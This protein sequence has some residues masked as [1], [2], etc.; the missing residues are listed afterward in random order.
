MKT[1]EI[2]MGWNYARYVDKVAEAGKGE[3][4]I[5]MFV[6]AWLPAP[7]DKGP[8]DYPSGGPQ[9][10]MHDIWR[11]AAPHVDMLCPDIYMTNF[12]E[13]AERYSRSGNILFVPECAGDIHGAAN[14]FYAIGQHKAVGYSSMGIG[15]LQ[16]LT[17]FRAGDAGSVAPADVANLPLPEAY[18]TLAQLAPLV[19]EHQTNGTIAGAWLTLAKKETHINLGGYILNVSLAGWGGRAVADNAIGYG[20]FM[21]TGPDEFLMAGDNLQIP[22][23]PGAPGP[24][25]VGLIEDAAGRFENGKWVVTRYLG[26]DD[27]TLRKDMANVVAEGQSGFGVRLLAQPHL[28]FAER[29]IQRVKVYRYK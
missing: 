1:D 14:A 21:A 11:A 29:A 4:A 9:A 15:E 24:E 8:G 17:A 5:P 26:G 27:S 22:F 28:S 6:N 7:T 2:F 25:F 20:I 3:Y 13:L 12:A 18:A 16:R 10:H 23:S 19:L